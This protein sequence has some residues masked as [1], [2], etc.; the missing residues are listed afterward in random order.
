[1]ACA[2][3]MFH[4]RYSLS[5]V[6]RRSSILPSAL[7]IFLMRI[8]RT[9]FACADGH[10]RWTE[11]GEPVRERG[12]EAASTMCC[13]ARVH[14][15]AHPPCPPS[16]HRARPQARTWVTLCN[17]EQRLASVQRPPR[18]PRLERMS[19]DSS[20]FRPTNEDRGTH[21]VG[22]KACRPRADARPW[23]GRE[24]WATHTM[25]ASPRLCSFVGGATFAAPRL[26]S[27]SL[28]SRRRSAESHASQLARVG[29]G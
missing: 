29:S 8:S 21:S 27:L 5:L 15:S 1:M 20:K 10:T 14:T 13:V 23:T 22:S 9:S 12:G 7:P 4:A 26:A 25:S 28:V 3:R 19:V 18:P 6:M 24:G 2:R 11:G 16:P 17:S